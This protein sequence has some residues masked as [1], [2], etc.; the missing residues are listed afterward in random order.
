MIR[1]AAGSC[2]T[3]ARESSQRRKAAAFS[4][5]CNTNS[6]EGPVS[7]YLGGLAT[8]L[9]RYDEA[10]AYFAQAA[11]FS[12]RV[13]AKFFAAG[14]D[15]REDAGLSHEG[16]HG[17]SGPRVRHRGTSG[18]GRP[19]TVGRLTGER[20]VARAISPRFQGA[21]P[22]RGPRIIAGVRAGRAEAMTD[23]AIRN[24]SGPRIQLGSRPDEGE[25]NQAHPGRDAPSCFRTPAADV[26]L[27]SGPATRR[28]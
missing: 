19:P 12:D 4:G 5:S 25:K 7:H 24:H 21:V 3:G 1:A 13:G 23:Q 27:S 6:V 26:L 28:S 8:V 14:T 9:G 17:R 18:C 15:H 11:A 2:A 16:A 20:G 10:D 22:D